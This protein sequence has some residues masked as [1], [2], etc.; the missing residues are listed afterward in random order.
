MIKK[1]ERI[2]YL[3]QM[4]GKSIS[5]DYK[6]FAMSD[7]G[8]LYNYVWYFLKQGLEGRSKVKNL[9]ETLVMVYQM[10]IEILSFDIILFMNNYFTE[11]RLVVVLKVRRIAVYGTMKHS[12]TDLLELLV[13]MKTVFVKNI[14]YGTLAVVT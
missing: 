6:F 5:E 12:W 10:A 14:S 1:I 9:G 7:E 8:Y 3:T 4:S 2:V 13:E 11:S